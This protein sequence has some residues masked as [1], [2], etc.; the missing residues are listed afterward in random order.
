MVNVTAENFLEATRSWC[1][2]DSRNADYQNGYI[3]GA[4]SMA[5]H[6]AKNLG[7]M[8]EILKLTPTRNEE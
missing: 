8:P 6:I 1:S 5:S 2:P 3:Q 7:L 4:A